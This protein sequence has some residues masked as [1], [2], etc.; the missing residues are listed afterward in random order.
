MCCG[1]DGANGHD[2]NHLTDL[3]PLLPGR[4]YEKWGVCAVT[5]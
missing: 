4:K 3:D 1:G 2:A 5:L